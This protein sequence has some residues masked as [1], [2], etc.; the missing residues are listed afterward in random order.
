MS[1]GGPLPGS[2]TPEP[3]G[4]AHPD[5]GVEKTRGSLPSTPDHEPVFFCDLCGS[6]MLNLHCKLVCERCG[7]KRDCSDP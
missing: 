3:A 5:G 4:T 7:Y 2:G 1:S 6:V